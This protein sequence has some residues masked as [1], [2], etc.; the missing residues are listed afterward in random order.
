[1]DNKTS[2]MVG[3]GILASAVIAGVSLRSNS[4]SPPTSSDKKVSKPIETVVPSESGYLNE[5]PEKQMASNT[6][7]VLETRNISVLSYD[8]YQGKAEGVRDGVQDSFPI[9]MRLYTD[10]KTYRSF[11]TVSIDR[12]SEGI[13]TASVQGGLSF[14]EKT[15]VFR[16]PKR[17]GNGFYSGTFEGG[18]AGISLDG[19]FEYYMGWDRYPSFNLSLIQEHSSDSSGPY[20][21]QVSARAD[22][23]AQKSSCG[24]LPSCKVYAKTKDG[25][26]L[27]AAVVGPIRSKKDGQGLK[28]FLISHY[29]DVSDVDLKNAFVREYAYYD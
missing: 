28:S 4:F 14:P 8:V 20:G 16:E 22:Y 15:F 5:T 23:S 13:S 3:A 17:K 26:T 27:Y 19:T 24:Q 29:S 21:L 9:T 12:G 10:S 11:G 6:P 25:N 7:S 2:L 18:S 1:M